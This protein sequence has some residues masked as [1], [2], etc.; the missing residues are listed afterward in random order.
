MDFL[1]AIQIVNELITTFKVN[2][3]Y[4]HKGEDKWDVNAVGSDMDI[5]RNMATHQGKKDSHQ[6]AYLC[7]VVSEGIHIWKILVN[8]VSDSWNDIGIWKTKLGEPI[9]NNYFVS[10]KHSGYS[11]FLSHGKKSIPESPGKCGPKYGV[12][13]R[14]CDIITMTLNFDTLTLSFKVNAIDYG[15]AFDIEKTTYR[16][17]ISCYYKGDGFSL[18][19]Y[20]HHTDGVNI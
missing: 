9:L 7:N 2:P 16:A 11:Y 19:S 5:V 8:K 6:S 1:K 10:N 3:R 14:S 18:L 15:K 12:A 4:E 13:C 17:A 20:T